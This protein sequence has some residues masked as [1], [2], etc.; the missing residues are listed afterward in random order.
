MPPASSLIA[1]AWPRKA[2]GPRL[3]TNVQPMRRKRIMFKKMARWYKDWEDEMIAVLADPALAATTAPGYRRRTANKLAGLSAIERQQMRAVSIKYRGRRALAPIARLILLFALIGT[4]MFLVFPVKDSWLESV[5]VIEVLGLSLSMALVGIW[6]NY[7]SMMEFKPKKI[8]KVALHV[9][10]G[11]LGGMGLIILIHGRPAFDALVKNA[12]RTALL[13][14]G[15]GAVFLL[16][17]GIVALYRNRQYDILT[18][19]LQH[20]SEQ[21]RM[22]RQLS[23]AQLRLLRSQIEPHFLFNTL[24][25][26]QQLA[27]RDAPRAAAL[28]ANLIDFL[29]ASMEE[30]RV[31][32]VSLV[33]EF[34]LVAAYL[35]VM[36]VRLGSR[37]RF[38]LTLP[39]ALA[40]AP[41]PSMMV[42]TLVENAIK[43]GI[44]PALRGGDIAVS[45]S[46]E[47]AQLQVLV[48]DSGAG[49]MPGA[50]D[51]FGLQNV[52]ERLQLAF[53]GQAALT[54]SDAPDGGALATL[55]LPLATAEGP[56]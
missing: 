1:S 29:R 3:G 9:V 19:Q 34:A 27:E 55:R 47:G 45:A 2:A 40:A 15:V 21:E 31:E 51:G 18:M 35:K 32:Q 8:A 22:A 44:E 30:M 38:T 43:H 46:R 16:L 28:T 25:A 12:P 6:Y 49:I 54:L 56:R 48:C 4:L 10:I 7:R 50:V 26:V 24:G 42:L 36:E 37:L 20:D 41:V 52:R 53:R 14:L 39:P 11:A 23:E 13:A 33:E 5:L 17:M